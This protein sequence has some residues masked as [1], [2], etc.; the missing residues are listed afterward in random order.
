MRT[1]S[2][3]MAAD[4]TDIDRARGMG[5]WPS[6]AA[7]KGEP[8]YFCVCTCIRSTCIC[9]YVYV[10]VYAHEC[11]CGCFCACV[12]VCMLFVCECVCV[13]LY[14]TCLNV[15]VRYMRFV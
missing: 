5:D 7:S 15:L 13:C 10:R 1:R 3:R 8:V 12:Y 11:G 4:E 2:G 14:V 6:S 9:K